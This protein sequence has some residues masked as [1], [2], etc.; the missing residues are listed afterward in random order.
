MADHIVADDEGLAAARS[1]RRSFA[2]VAQ[3]SPCRV[4]PPRK[5]NRIDSPVATTSADAGMPP[6]AV[7]AFPFAQTSPSIGASD[8]ARENVA[9]QDRISALEL[10]LTNASQQVITLPLL[11]SMLERVAAT[12]ASSAA[13]AA[14]SAA[15]AQQHLAPEPAAQTSMPAEAVPATPQADPMDTSSF[16]H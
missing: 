15:Q 1:S 2:E 13:A 12:A 3:S 6:S 11:E 5:D 10:A 8:I 7:V 9:L 14:V 16:F 4:S